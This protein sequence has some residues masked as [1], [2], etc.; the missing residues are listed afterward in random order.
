V[1]FTIRR[2]ILLFTV[3]PA[4][5]ILALL[6]GINAYRLYR[7][8]TVIVDQEMALVARRHA[9][10]IDAAMREAA[11]VA[12]TTAA[13]V[14]LSESLS[15]AEYY[16]LLRANVS[17]NEVIYG[18][19]LAFEPGAIDPERRLFCPYVHQ[20]PDGLKELDIGRD[21]YD[22]TQPEWTWWNVPKK[23]GKPEWTDPYF[24]EG[25]GNALMIT[26]SAPIFRQGK[27]FGV[28]TVDIGLAPFHESILNQMEPGLEFFITDRRGGYVFR[29]NDSSKSFSGNLLE[30]GRLLGRPDVT[31]LGVRLISEKSGAGYVPTWMGPKKRQWVY[32]NSLEVS[33]WCFSLVVPDER[34]MAPVRQELYRNMLLLLAAIV[35]VTTGASYASR[36]ITN[37]LERLHAAAVRVGAGDLDV[38]PEVTSNDEFGVLS[39]TFSD[40][41]ERLRRSFDSLREQ[42]QLLVSETGSVLY[43]RGPEKPWPLHLLGDAIEALSGYSVSDLMNDPDRSLEDIVFPEDRC[44]VEKGFA[45][46]L[47]SGGDHALEY[48]IVH[49]DGRILWVYNRGRCVRDAQGQ[50]QY[51]T[52]VITDI[53]DLKRLSEELAQAKDQAEDATRAKSEFLARMSHEIRTPMNAIIGMSHLA[54]QTHLTPKQRDYVSKTYQAAHSLLGIIND[55]LDFSKIEAGRMEIE[56]VDF[57]LEEVLANLANVVMLKAEERG[58]ELLVNSDSSLPAR[59]VGD[60][61]RL[62]QVLINLTNNALKFTETGEVIVTVKQLA[63]TGDR[64]KVEFAVRDTGIGITPEQQSR[65]FESFMQ[66]DSA[67]TRR[68]G[69]TG[70]GLAI[71]RRLV[72]MMGGE[73]TVSSAL[74][75]GSTFSFTAEFG[76]SDAVEKP[77]PAINP[78]LHG[79]KVLVVDDN[80]TAR[81]ILLSMLESFSFDVTLAAS[82]AE[83]LA[84][85]DAPPGGRPFELVLMDWKMPGMNGVDTIQRIKALPHLKRTPKVIMVTAYGREE[86]MR[87]AESAGVR[88]SAFLLKPVSTSVLLETIMQILGYELASSERQVNGAAAADPARLS[89]LRGAH[90]LVVDDNEINRQVVQELLEGP[91]LSVAVA[92]NGREGVRA[93]AETKFDLIFMDI[94]MPEMD[95]LEATRRIR[96]LPGGGAEELPIVAMTAHAMASDRD[97]SL[98]A[99]MNDHITKPINPAEL[100]DTLLRWIRPAAGAAVEDKKTEGAGDMTAESFLPGED[101]PGL[102]VH[103]GVARLG[104]NAR[105]YLSLLEKFAAQY[106]VQL[107][108][109][110]QLL[111]TAGTD[112]AL[113]IVHK[114]KGVAGN[115]SA[116]RLHERLVELEMALHTGG[117]PDRIALLITQVNEDMAIVT[118]SIQTLTERAA[119]SAAAPSAKPAGESAWLLGALSGLETYLSAHKPRPSREAVAAMTEFAWPAGIE[120][121]LARLSRAVARYQ[122]KDAQQLAASLKTQLEG[123]EEYAQ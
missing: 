63:Q 57:S 110:R 27:F 107:A 30:E 31:A 53:T 59:M 85:L 28:A 111:Q 88:P 3:V 22:Y 67:T 35:A 29:G 100:Y 83:A 112:E 4:V 104:G 17:Q 47:E 9:R 56:A 21:G 51:L 69:G 60:P 19:A 36:L 41:A 64:L 103:E 121:V 90:V 79:M 10:T 2:K 34:I 116:Q 97:K 7:R 38:S 14:G 105:L 43:R 89:P 73:L 45:D 114:I 72:G 62:G 13:F 52:G 39:R 26:Y 76:V 55:I 58:L 6:L 71:C 123:N 20:S 98:E 87:Q 108:G 18:A 46:C 113:Q 99:G 40:M 32:F 91:G 25:A 102:S 115:I 84:L 106:P 48:R 37:P 78:N 16:G 61:L 92:E 122:F 77:S 5:L 8:Q 118:E 68:Y 11:Q 44:R 12:R 80:P 117:A 23:S 119:A 109:L 42:L 94:Q 95:G 86:I 1:R 96:A 70:L 81:E 24:D 82:G 54:L 15:E 33:Q 65:L 75:E 93:A 101:L 66:A 50:P 120:A 74:G 49:R